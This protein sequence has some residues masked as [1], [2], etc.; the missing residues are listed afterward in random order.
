MFEGP[1]R[2]KPWVSWLYVVI[3]SLT[4]FVTIPLARAIQ[5]YISENWGRELFTYVVLV[6]IA[7][8]FIVAIYC[9]IKHRTASLGSYSWLLALAAI[10]V[11]YTIKL[12][13]RSPEEAIHF[14]QYGVLGVFVY[15]A[16]THRL[17]DVSIYFAAAIICAII[18]TIDEIIQW[19]TPKR[20]WGIK[21]IW[22][23]FF[24]S[25]LV[26]IAIAKGLKP[27]FIFSIPN[28]ANLRLLCR[29]VFVVVVLLGACFL[30]T[31]QRI[32]WYAGRIPLLE[33][34]IE[35]ESVMLEYGYLYD[36]PDIGI[37]RSR[38]P[39]AHLK[40]SDQE[41]ANE[42]A[43]ILDLYQDDS[44]YQEFLRIFTP[45]S[46][47]FLHEVRVHLFRRD[48]NFANSTLNKDNPIKHAKHL[49][50]AFREN[51]IVERYFP[52]TLLQS[53][54]V[55]SQDEFTLAEEHLLR[56]EVY[57]SGVSRR[58][59]TRISEDQVIGFF[60]VLIFGLAFVHWRLGKNK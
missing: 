13:Q 46:D 16:L 28:R 47:P 4:I 10:F 45:V 33:F 34:L 21:D 44:K 42:A 29:F 11:G 8:A 60:V 54:Y 18:G 23:N 48:R 39:L 2:E 6:N 40:Q 50:I 59:I 24:A 58:L 22:L 43:E 12:G 53:A 56:N 7:I 9:V 32:A 17:Q 51:Q 1:P 57:V 52:N 49:T 27:K 36:D 19:L 3:W 37:F 14:I 25:S 41:R 35:N 15:R 38:L 31:P 30:N 20:Y 55:W 5:Q 26:Q